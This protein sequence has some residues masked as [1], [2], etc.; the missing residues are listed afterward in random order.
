MHD[1]CM[2]SGGDDSATR[3]KDS[4]WRPVAAIV[5]VLAIPFVMQVYSVSWQ[6]VSHGM[7]ITEWFNSTNGTATEEV[8]KG[9]DASAIPYVIDEYR[10][11][12]ARS[13]VFF[14]ALR[15]RFVGKINVRLAES[16]RYRALSALMI[17][18]RKDPVVVEPFL[19]E[20][21]GM[22]H[23]RTRD[24]ALYILGTLGARH[25]SLLTNWVSSTNVADSHA[26]MSGLVQMGTNAR[27]AIPLFISRIWG[28]PNGKSEYS[29]FLSKLPIMGPD[30]VQTLPTLLSSIGDPHESVQRFGLAGLR[31]MTNHFPTSAAE[32]LRV[33]KLPPVGTNDVGYLPTLSMAR[34]GVKPDDGIP[35]ILERLHMAIS[36]TN[37]IRFYNE[38]TMMCRVLR[39][40]G[41]NANAAIP[42][43]EN[44]LLPAWQREL[45][46]ANRVSQKRISGHVKMIDELIGE[47]SP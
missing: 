45:R 5:C 4:R 46:S 3:P 20:L 21:L 23:Q 43:L 35:V 25:F 7:T 39:T 2:E 15:E 29:Y 17:L 11:A 12:E 37:R 33:S 6:P 8:L 32:V 31:K 9:F 13:H 10:K 16:R 26:A 28:Q 42:F 41:T 1:L 22:T 40:W 44:E 14:R 27:S 38:T 19:F 24:Y 34:L 18:G 30:H 47:L 36:L